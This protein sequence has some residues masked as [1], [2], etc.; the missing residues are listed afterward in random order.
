MAIAEA[1]LVEQPAADEAG[2][3]E[4]LT[5]GEA[6]L[7][8]LLSDQSGLDLAE[9][10]W[11]DEATPDACWRAYPFQWSWWRAKQARGVD[12]GA[13]SIGKSER[14]CAGACAF[15]FSYPQNEHAITAP[16]GGHLDKLTDRIEMRIRACWLL[17][18]MV[19][20][21]RGGITHRPFKI[22]WAN[23]ARTYTMLPQR[24]GIGVKGS[25]PV[26]LDVDEA[27]DMSERTWKELPEVVRW[28]VPGARWTCHGVSKGVRDQFFD[29][30][31]PNSGWDV[32]HIT[33]MQK[34]TWNNEEREQ[35]IKDYGGSPESP[36]Y[37]RNVLG[38]HGD[39]QNRIFV[40]AALMAGVDT[41]ETSDYLKFEY[42]KRTITGD[43]IASRLGS[44]SAV[45]ASTAEAIAEIISLVDI[46]KTH[47]K[48]DTTWVGMDVGL[49]GDPTEILVFGEYQPDA[50]ERAEHRRNAIAVPEEGDSRFKLLTR[51]QLF[52]LPEPL[53]VELLMW[54]IDVY[55]PK[56][57]ALD[58][59]GIGLPLF[60]A[61]QQKA[62]TS[63]LVSF[64]VDANAS[65]EEKA[66]ASAEQ[67]KARH[68]L[69]VIKNYKFNEKVLIEFDETRAAELPVGA[70]TQE[71]V[72]KAGIKQVAK[73]RATDVLR[74]LVDHR[75]M[76]FPLDDE[77]INQ[78]NGQTYSY[79]SEP[80][81]AYG[82][83]R[84]VYSS[85][86]FHILDA[87]RMFA[88]AWSQ[89]RIEELMSTPEPPRKPVIDSFL[90]GF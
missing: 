77:V 73:D 6:Y 8:A 25:H 18:Q 3:V 34:P 78:M 28:E 67:G 13:R 89:A 59:T 2:V 15:P 5:A 44:K 21:G 1:D 58:G 38:D 27:Q 43:Q 33:A 79:S 75:R 53:Q 9:F 70:T 22:N 69:T 85:G 16:E 49:V 52:R 74:T 48:Y 7:Y 19:R 71:I 62:G 17:T 87:A 68:A 31:Q 24:S 23:G 60:Q 30:T 55:R 29:I 4:A 82:K 47:A 35:K 72:E 83:R 86:T 57:L 42:F 46:P 37:K 50:K 61:L 64:E 12:Q 90:G 26:W 65:D 40:L 63:R 14:I 51:L 39:S 10:L 88:L 66:L 41:R 84:M 54:V 11:T 56:A 36:D 76:L 20:G 80:V 32:N 45:E 81:D